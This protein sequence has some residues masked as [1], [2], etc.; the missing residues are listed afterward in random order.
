MLSLVTLLT[1]SAPVQ[2]SKPALRKKAGVDQSSHLKNMRLFGI[3]L[4]M[5][6]HDAKRA[7]VRRG[8]K[9]EPAYKG[10]YP[11]AQMAGSV[12]YSTDLT[13]PLVDITYHRFHN[14]MRVTAIALQEDVKYSNDLGKDRLIARRYGTPTNIEKTSYGPH[15]S[16]TSN[17]LAPDRTEPNVTQSCLS[18][19]VHCVS[20]QVPRHCPANLVRR[21]ITMTATFGAPIPGKSRLYLQLSDTDA[22]FHAVYQ[23]RDR[24]P[25]RATCLPPVAD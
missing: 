1:S 5:P 11:N 6:V 21:G 25:S 9:P 13:V 19:F 24:L 3:R 20:P 15:Y 4:G 14:G 17:G 23:G 22:Q 18:V 8:L 12:R 16:W 7:L 2:A 10:P